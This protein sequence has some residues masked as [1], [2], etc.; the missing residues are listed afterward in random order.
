MPSK[1]QLKDHI[2]SGR[3]LKKHD[4]SENRQLQS[5]ETKEI[6]MK[7]MSINAQLKDHV[8]SDVNRHSS[9]K[10]FVTPMCQ[11]APIKVTC[12][13]KNHPPNNLSTVCCHTQK[14][15]VPSAKKDLLCTTSMP[16]TTNRGN[17]EEQ[18][19][20]ESCARGPISPRRLDFESNSRK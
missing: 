6:Q 15:T 10:T 19:S 20:S 3:M 17:N 1:A 2:P 14:V 9:G 12:S 13:S 16:L 8:P 11:N 5:S 4:A 18:V 7:G